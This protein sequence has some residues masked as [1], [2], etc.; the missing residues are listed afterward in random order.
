[1]IVWLVSELRSNSS[2]L[3]LH[4]CT[5]LKNVRTFEHLVFAGDNFTYHPECEFVPLTVCELVK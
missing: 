5:G 1:M 3:S 2:F 4:Q